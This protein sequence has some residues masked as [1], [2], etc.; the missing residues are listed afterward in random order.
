MPKLLCL[1]DSLTYGLG[2]RPNQRWT[3]LLQERGIETV[4]LGVNGDTAAGMLARLQNLSFPPESAAVLVMGGTNDIFC[5]GTDTGARACMA[6]ILQQLLAMGRLPIVGIPIPVVPDMAP[7][8]W[9]Q[10]VDFSAAAPVLN[11]YC[12]WLQ[13]YC[14][15]FDITAVDF[16]KDYVNLD[17]TVRLELYLDGLHPN[18]EGHR[19]MA[20]RI[21]ET[22]L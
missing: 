20:A 10:L 11:R 21:L 8:K 19:Q 7:E 18:A 22:K 12:A 16:R 2:V 9:R 4:N 3:H 6:A 1:G 13:T 5:A 17:G 14:R 15:T